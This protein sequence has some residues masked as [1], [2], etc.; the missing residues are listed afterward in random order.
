MAEIWVAAGAAVI[1]AGATVY[2]ANK[3]AKASKAA[4]DAN[5]AA[6]EASNEQAWTGYL[7]QRGLAAPEGT[8]AGVLPGSGTAVNTKLPLWASVK[9]SST[10]PMTL[11]RK[12][13]ATAP[14]DANMRMTR[15]SFSLPRAPAPLAG[16][17]DAAAP[18]KKKNKAVEIWKKGPGLLK[19]LF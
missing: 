5:L 16:A 18:E 8:A 9:R 12:G 15:A 4:N 6:N 17:G 10:A 2:G 14:A 3:Q 13:T 1:G 19:K 7:M 11:R